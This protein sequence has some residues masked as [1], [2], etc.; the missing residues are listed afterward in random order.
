MTTCALVTGLHQRDLKE[1]KGLPKYVVD[2]LSTIRD[3]NLLQK[4]L[5]LNEQEM[6]KNTGERLSSLSAETVIGYSLGAYATV[7]QNK[8]TAKQYVLISPAIPGTIKSL[9]LRLL[10]KIHPALN[11]FNIKNQ[12]N[13]L[14]RL[15]VLQ[16]PVTL[17]LPIDEKYNCGDDTISYDARLLRKLE[18]IP[19]V[20]VRFVH[21]SGK[22]SE[23]L[24]NQEALNL[25][26]DLI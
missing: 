26:K 3:Q 16:V 13:F 1:L 17:I 18:R 6:L 24:E 10:G 7:M 23:I 12:D 25:L 8:H 20:K 2:P 15:N 14:V 11:G 5:H 22:H 9:K 19:N 21:T 4:F